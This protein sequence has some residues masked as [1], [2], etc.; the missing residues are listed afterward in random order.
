M[1]CYVYNPQD[2]PLQLLPREANQS[3]CDGVKHRQAE[4]SKLLL[5]NILFG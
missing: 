3:D 2:P 1:I 5:Q 4:F